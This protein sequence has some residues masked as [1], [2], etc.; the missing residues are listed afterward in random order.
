MD[1]SLNITR[2]QVDFFINSLFLDSSNPFL[3]GPIVTD[4]LSLALG[5]CSIPQGSPTPSH[6]IINK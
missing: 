6:I 2:I 1:D 5:S 3:S 4:L